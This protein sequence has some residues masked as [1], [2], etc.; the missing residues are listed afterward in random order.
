RGNSFSV[1]KVDNLPVVLDD[2]SL[3]IDDLE[4][5]L[6]LQLRHLT[7]QGKR[8]LEVVR[9]STELEPKPTHQPP[10]ASSIAG[11]MNLHQHQYETEEY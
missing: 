6:L 11:K 10:K 5:A 3:R 9:L 7:N 1:T 8:Q 2:W 4:V